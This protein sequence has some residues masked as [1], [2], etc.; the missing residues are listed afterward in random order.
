MITV[1]PE[2][3]ALTSEWIATLD[4][5]VNAQI[6]PQVSGYLL[7]RNYEEGA[8]V[9]K[10]QVLFEIDRAAVRG[11]AGAGAAQL[12]EAQ[13]QLG[14]TER[15][16]AARSPAGRAARDRAEP[17]RQRRPGEPRG[18]G[19][20]ASRPTAAVET[21]QLN[22]G[23]TKVDVADRRRR[24]DRDRADRRPRRAD[25][26]ADDGVADRSDQGVLPAER[27]GIPADRRPR[28]TARRAQ[29]PWEGARR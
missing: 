25:D 23:F 5:Y 26:A 22:V 9:R 10:G 24:G 15:D 20:R 19:G 13:A 6:R 17:A 4:G 12:A 11:G 28:S 7:K 21:A 8:V 1:A 2:R 3:V 14:K 29:A 18:A 16:L 27:A